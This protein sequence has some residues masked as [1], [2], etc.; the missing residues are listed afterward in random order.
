MELKT[1]KQ[2]VRHILLEHPEARNS[3]MEL[4]VCYL[5]KFHRNRLS[6]TNVGWALPLENFKHLPPF[7]NLRR[8]RQIIQNDNGEFLPTDP[9]VIKDRKIKEKNWYN[10]EVREAQ[11][12][13]GKKPEQFV[14]KKDSQGR[15][16][17]SVV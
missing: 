9:Q 2:R 7:E 13:G 12:M 11:G 17:A 10:A 8:C 6:D 15:P 16:I 14:V 3:D 1:Y 4:F 5:I